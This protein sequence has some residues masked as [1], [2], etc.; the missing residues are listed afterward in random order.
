MAAVSIMIETDS[1]RPGEKEG[2]VLFKKC[3]AWGGT[4]KKIPRRSLTSIE[5]NISNRAQRR[6]TGVGGGENSGVRVEEQELGKKAARQR[7]Q[8]RLITRTM[9]EYR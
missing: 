4:E 7:I 9:N 5:W 8:S 3:A 2:Q 1:E 6:E